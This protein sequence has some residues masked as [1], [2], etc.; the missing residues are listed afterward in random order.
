[1]EKILNKIK[2]LGKDILIFFGYF[3][4]MLVFRTYLTRGNSYNLTPLIET[5]IYLLLSIY[6]FIVFRKELKSSLKDFKKNGRGYLK[7]GFQ[8]Y[9]KAYLLVIIIQLILFKLVGNLPTNEELNREAI[10]NSIFY[11]ALQMC[12]FAPFQ[13]ELVFRLNFRNL[14]KNKIIFSFFTGVLFGS[15]HLLVAESLIELLYIVTYSIMGFVLGYMYFDSDN[16][17]TSMCLH[18]FNNTFALVITIIGAF[19]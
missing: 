6:L 15:M 10:R 13:E 19:I 3:L 5:I 8:I 14:F 18:A 2:L 4:L 12:I 11:S 7:K 16:I 9:F 1:M 17:Y